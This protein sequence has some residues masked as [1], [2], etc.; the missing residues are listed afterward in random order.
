MYEINIFSILIPYDTQIFI[1]GLIHFFLQELTA[2]SS[3]NFLNG[4]LY[5]LKFKILLI[6]YTCH[7]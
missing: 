7:L 6:L 5:S 2:M 4:E 1:S 3:H